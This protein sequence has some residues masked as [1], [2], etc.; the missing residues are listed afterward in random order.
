MLF[1]QML[2]VF[3]V[4]L[5]SSI[6]P[7]RV[8]IVQ[9]HASAA[10]VA[11]SGTSPQTSASFL[12][13]SSLTPPYPTVSALV[14]P[15]TMSQ[16]SPPRPP[17]APFQSRSFVVS[18]SMTSAQHSDPTEQTPPQ[19]ASFER[20]AVV[21]RNS[22]TNALPE[23][24]LHALSSHQSRILP[25]FQEPTTRISSRLT[26]TQVLQD[27][28]TSGGD[29]VQRAQWFAQEL[30]GNV[31]YTTEE[32][33]RFFENVPYNAGVTVVCR[34][35]SVEDI[36]TQCGKAKAYGDS[37]YIPV[38]QHV[39][40]PTVGEAQSGELWEDVDVQNKEWFSAIAQLKKL[41]PDLKIIGLYL[42]P[43]DH[44]KLHLIMER[45]RKFI[46][47]IM[48]DWE[49]APQAC[50]DKVERSPPQ[51][52]WMWFLK[53]KVRYMVANQDKSSCLGKDGNRADEGP[54]LNSSGRGL[55]F[56]DFI[57]PVF[58]C[59]FGKEWRCHMAMRDNPSIACSA[60]KQR[61]AFSISD[62]T[63]IATFKYFLTRCQE[64]QGSVPQY[65]LVRAI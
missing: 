2:I 32:I 12:S 31:D 38:L 54:F 3:I 58:P 47:G 53:D 39:P 61:Y 33:E 25:L 65:D 29:S 62:A 21:S 6:A 45:C 36:V 37:V 7:A 15:F 43:P 50:W 11:G 16:R 57:I 19:A 20:P 59:Y 49:Y 18:S 41:N 48:V 23:G 17:S 52:N 1:A 51:H 13:T 8:S 9:I 28:N 22:E 44:G 63:S 14:S 10:A 64:T 34:P 40:S 46:D 30:S 24:F 27:A 42:G 5:F 26:F 55:P 60:E 56:P 35:S 4:G